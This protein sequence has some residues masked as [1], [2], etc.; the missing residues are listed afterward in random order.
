MRVRPSPGAAV[1]AAAVTC[2]PGRATRRAPERYARLPVPR[3]TSA[4]LAWATSSCASN[5]RRGRSSRIVEIRLGNEKLSAD[6]AFERLGLRDTDPCGFAVSEIASAFLCSQAAIEKR[7]SRAKKV[8][9][10]SKRL[11]DLG[12]AATSPPGSRPCSARCTCCS[13]R[14][15]TARAQSQPYAPS[16]AAKRCA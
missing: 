1:Q 14:A 8:L 11:F 16:F 5:D 4:S 6:A 10:G 3:R 15:T 13:T 12:D 9:A 2:F 7:I